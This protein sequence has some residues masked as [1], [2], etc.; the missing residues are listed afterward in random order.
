MW[1]HQAH[2]DLLKVTSKF[3]IAFRLALKARGLAKR[4]YDQE[5]DK[6]YHS[7]YNIL[8]HY[9]QIPSAFKKW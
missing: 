8:N 4:T 6:I 7:P 5:L 3:D 2:S 1:L 9:G